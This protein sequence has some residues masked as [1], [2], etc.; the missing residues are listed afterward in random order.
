MIRGPRGA[1]RSHE[2]RWPPLDPGS[3]FE[4]EPGRLLIPVKS[5]Y[6]IAPTALKFHI[7]DGQIVFEDGQH[8]INIDAMLQNAQKK[9]GRKKKS[10]DEALE[11][12]I[13]VLEDEKSLPSK[14][15]LSRGDAEGFGE[16]AIRTAGKNPQIKI[17]KEGFGKDGVWVWS[18]DK[19]FPNDEG[20]QVQ[21]LQNTQDTLS[22][23]D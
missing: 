2:G 22:G 15:V 18:L 21:T 13:C 17:V 20:S 14:E 7:V 16:R 8:Q 3:D 10:A 11:W 6:S 19:P 5:N 1:G 12:L 9:G 23:A 4:G